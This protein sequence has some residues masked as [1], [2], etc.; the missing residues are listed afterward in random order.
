MSDDLCK[1]ILLDFF[2]YSWNSLASLVRNLESFDRDFRKPVSLFRFVKGRR[3]DSTFSGN[4]FFLRGSTE[5]SNPQLT[6]EEVQ[7]MIAARLLEVCGNYFHDNGLR[8]PEAGDVV[9]LCEALKKPP[10]GL[11]IPFLFNTDDVEPDR[12]SM[13]PLRKSIL[14][15]GQSAFPAAS[16]KTDCLEIDPHFFR[17]YDGSLISSDEVGLIK[18]YLD[19]GGDSYLDLVDSVKHS[20]ME[21]LSEAMGIDLSLHSLRMPLETLRSE[22]EEDLLHQII[23]RSHQSLE[24]IKLAYRC[25]RRSITKRRTLLTIPHSE[26]GFG[27]KR[28]ARGK[29]RFEGQTL[30][31][32]EVRYKTTRLY[33]NEVDPD[34]LSI[35]KAEDSFEVRGE[36][37]SRYSFKETPFSPLFFMYSLG[38]PE[39]GAVWHGVGTFASPK[40]LRSCASIR[41]TFRGSQLTK[42]LFKKRMVKADLPLQFNLSPNSMWVHPIHRN[43]DASMGSIKNLSDLAQMGMKIDLLSKF[44]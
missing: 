4:H 34:D 27:S 33:S 24:S 37:L 14:T 31:S 42:D 17:K 44:T 21:Q 32:V 35:A 26:K 13:N 10:E 9:Q 20:Q 15:S 3:I 38:S 40:L 18:S 2:K 36:K 8:E 25:M 16:V 1:S 11:I 19:A 30:R 5:Y 7:G 22:T 43:I 29:L 41:K 12:Y 23:S 28:T 6:V 39:D